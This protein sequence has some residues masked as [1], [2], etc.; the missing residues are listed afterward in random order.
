MFKQILLLLLIVFI[1]LITLILTVSYHFSPAYLSDSFIGGFPVLLTAFS[2]LCAVYCICLVILVFFL[3]DRNNSLRAKNYG[4]EKSQ[5]E[6]ITQNKTL[7]GK[8]DLL[9]ATREISLI[10]THEV[11]FRKILEKSLAIIAQTINSSLEDRTG[12]NREEITIFLKDEI[13]GRLMP[14]AQRKGLDIVFDDVLS[15]QIDWR[16]VNESLEHSR[17]FFS[18]DGEILDFTIP[19]TADRDAVGVLKARIPAGPAAP[20]EEHIKQL[21]DNLMELARV[22]ALAVKTPMLYNRAITDGL[23]GLYS[24]RHL[25]TELSVYLEISRRHDTKLSF[26][27]F[28]IDHFK[29]VNDTFG[30]LTGD[31]VLKNVSATLKQTLR[32]TSTAYRYGGEEM[33]IILPLSS[34]ADAGIFAERLRKKIENQLFTSQSGEKLKITISLGVA[35]YQKAMTD[36]KDLIAQADTA[37]YQAKQGGRKQTVVI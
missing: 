32:A 1:P 13:S 20:Q 17:L 2:S 19:L 21:Q 15:E 28:D 6:I 31:M 27:M 18:A 5:S 33:A 4:L 8:I 34:K 37:L 7:T 10:I 22:L 11:D 35:E 36:F 3:N 9:S 23:T 24:K 26:I 12:D 25:L 14:H 29:K 16:N 30:H